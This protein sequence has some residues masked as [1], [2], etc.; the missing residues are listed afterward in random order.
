MCKSLPGQNT[1]AGS[2]PHQEGKSKS[3][4]LLVTE[5]P[6]GTRKAGD[7]V[8]LSLHGD[9]ELLREKGPYEI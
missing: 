8:R 5:T 9:W 2:V 1:A 7:C 3:G 6:N 4:L